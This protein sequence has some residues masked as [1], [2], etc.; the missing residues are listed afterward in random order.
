MNDGSLTKKR[1]ETNVD[2]C[3]WCGALMDQFDGVDIS[4]GG[5]YQDWSCSVCGKRG[6]DVYVFS[7]AID[8]EGNT[9]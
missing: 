9:I 4:N 7:H 3:P 5:A 6:T 2:E 1:R 8:E